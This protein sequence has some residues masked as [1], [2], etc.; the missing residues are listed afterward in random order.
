LIEI[1]LTGLVLINKPNGYG[2]R[3]AG[4]SLNSISPVT[5]YKL[6][7]ASELATFT[8]YAP[9]FYVMLFVICRPRRRNTFTYLLATLAISLSWIIPQLIIYGDNGFSFGHYLFPV[10]VG[11]SGVC[12]LAL[13]ILWQ[14][15]N[16]ILWTACLLWILLPVL[17]GVS[18]TTK[19][20]SSFTAQSIAFNEMVNYLAENM[21]EHQAILLVADPSGQFEWTLSVRTHL[22]FAGLDAPIYLL[23]VYSEDGRSDE[24]TSALVN[25]QYAGFMDLESLHPNEVGAIIAFKSPNANTKVPSWFNPADW[26]L[27]NFTQNYYTFSLQKLAYEQAGSYEHNILIPIAR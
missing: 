9:V 11:F 10:I 25:I 20:S 15:R 3:V 7:T 22:R 6:L 5:W 24:L 16:W 14:K 12:A 2:A 8:Y 1:I 26:Q 27:L 19:R 21:D 4:L 18:S 13:S 17:A 23:P